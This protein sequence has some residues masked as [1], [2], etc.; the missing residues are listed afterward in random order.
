VTGLVFD[1]SVVGRV[2]DAARRQRRST[3]IAL[4][5]VVVNHVGITSMFAACNSGSIDLNCVTTSC[6]GVPAV[7]ITA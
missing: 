3:L 4:A 6:A 2:V 1:E 5:S 7:F